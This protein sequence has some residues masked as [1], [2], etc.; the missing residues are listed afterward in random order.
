MDEIGQRDRHAVAAERRGELRVERRRRQAIEAIGED[1][2][3]ALQRVPDDGLRS[4]RRGERLELPDAERVDDRDLVAD[5]EL[6]DHQARRVR[7]LVVEL[8]VER[9]AFD[10]ADAVAEGGQGRGFLDEDDV[11]GFSGGEERC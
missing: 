6:H 10:R 1:L 8:G 11:H 7:L 5:D 9:D 4:E 2:Q 3:V